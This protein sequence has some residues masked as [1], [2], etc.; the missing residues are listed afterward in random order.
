MKQR[1]RSIALFTRYPAAN[2]DRAE[3]K[4]AAN[5]AKATGGVCAMCR[6][7]PKK[8]SFM[9]AHVSPISVEIIALANFRPRKSALKTEDAFL[10]TDASSTLPSMVIA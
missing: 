3:V 1:C 8:R 7:V 5:C 9:K 10:S 6:A 4:L 2:F